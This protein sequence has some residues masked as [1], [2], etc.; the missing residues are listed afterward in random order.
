MILAL[1]AETLLEHGM[2]RLPGFTT[3]GPDIR[4]VMERSRLITAL[5][6][7]IFFL[8]R[9]GEFLPKQIR[10]NCHHV[11]MQRYHLRFLDAQ[12]QP[13]P[14]H[15]IH[16]QSVQWLNITIEF[17]KADQSG[18]GRITTHRLDPDNPRNC[19]VSR[20]ASYIALSRDA[21]GAA[22]HDLLFTVPSFPHFDSSSLTELMRS[23]CTHVGI[24]PERV[25]AHSLRYGGATTLAA[26]GFPDYIIAF[27][28]GWS[29]NSTAMRRY[30]R[31][32]NDI[33][34][35][36]SLHMTRTTH[37][38]SVQSFVNQLLAQQPM[39]APDSR[40]PHTKRPVRRVTPT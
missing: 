29:P 10:A 7:G 28:G 21:F 33:V 11:P 37:S 3:F 26:A 23:T 14:Y 38:D 40:P 22:V 2:V 4:A 5:F 31:P 12:Q 17:S 36:V 34:T 15:S 20:M 39:V 25:S 35:K 8:L 32:S 1:Q 13:V 18:N 6:F 30:I 19:V 24:S 16:P 9:K 27:Y